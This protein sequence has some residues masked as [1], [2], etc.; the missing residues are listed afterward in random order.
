MTYD[1]LNLAGKTAL[2]TGG[3]T[4][5]G[6]AAAQLLAARGAQ[7]LITGRNEDRLRD[8][9]ATIPG[10]AW[11]SNDAADPAAADALAAWATTRT[12]RL[13]IVVL[14]AGV[15]P[16][17]PPEGY[18]PERI[19][20]LLAANIAGPWLQLRALDPL[21]ADHGAIIG[22]GSIAGSK[23]APAN[24]LYGASKAAL[25]LYLRA[26]APHYGA[27]RIRVNVVSPGPVDTP[28]WGKTGLPE[29][30]VDQIRE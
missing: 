26:L 19:D 23:S 10:A 13:D 30:V 21:L 9:A 4:G 1:A 12:S 24:A 29:A 16:F 28:A 17:G 2:V 5:I 18:G 7:V 27:R 3:S 14:N 6:L 20:P 25:S 11:L 8:A 22:I 15:T